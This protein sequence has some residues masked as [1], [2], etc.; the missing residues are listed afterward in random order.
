MNR[1]YKVALYKIQLNR[2]ILFLVFWGAILVDSLNGYLQT[3]QSIYIPIGVLYRG[4]I[5]LF[6]L[7]YVDFKSPSKYFKRLYAIT[8]MIYCLAMFFWEIFNPIGGIGQNVVFLLRFLYGFLLLCFFLRMR[9][10]LEVQHIVRLV[11]NSSTFICLLNFACLVLGIGNQTYRDAQFGY[12]AFYIDGNSLGIYLVMSLGLAI[13]SALV[14]K[15]ML[16]WV[17]TIIITF[18]TLLVASRAAIGGTFVVWIAL[19]CYVL[20]FKNQEVKIS[21]LKRLVLASMIICALLLTLGLLIKQINSSDAFIVARFTLESA[22]SPRAKLLF[23]WNDVVA[24]YDLKEW[25]LGVGTVAGRE[26]LGEILVGSEARSIEAD[27][28]ETILFFGCGLG[29]LVL[30]CFIYPLLR[31]IYYWCKKHSLLNFVI[32]LLYVMW[33]GHAYM[34][35]HCFTDVIQA[36]LLAILFCINKPQDINELST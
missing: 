12:K 5:S 4:V 10:K 30:I 16:A 3:S 34:A 7:R 32:V 36:P 24:N 28:H 9:E 8:F 27:F 11:V 20:F 6:L 35:G 2:L 26:Q 25:L 14:E 31:A 23:A 17:K 29:G 1:I 21:K 18:G 22:S 15:K 33:I 13:W 19:V